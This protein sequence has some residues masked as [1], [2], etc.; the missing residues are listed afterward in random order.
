M[1]SAQVSMAKAIV[2]TD[3]DTAAAAFTLFPIEIIGRYQFINMGL[4]HGPSP[5]HIFSPI[6]PN[7]IP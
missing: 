6:I 2:R 3:T 7:Y 4:I 5:F 1:P